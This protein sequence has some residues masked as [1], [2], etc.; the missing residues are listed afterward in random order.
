MK[1]M[2]WEELNEYIEGARKDPVFMSDLREFIRQTTGKAKK[3]C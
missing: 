3:R 2:S 1:R